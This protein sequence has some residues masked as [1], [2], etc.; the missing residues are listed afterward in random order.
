MFPQTGE[1]QQAMAGCLAVLRRDPQAMDH[2]G[3]DAG[4]LLRSFFAAM[5]VFPLLLLRS[6]AAG[7]PGAT[8]AAAGGGPQLSFLAV[9]LLYVVSWL[10][11]PVAADIVVRALGR[12][13]RQY[14]RY[15]AAYNWSQV[16]VAAL[17]LVATTIAPQF[18]FVA[19]GLSLLYL[20]LLAQSA[21]AITL[22]GAVGLVVLDFGLNLV[23]Q[24]VV[25]GAAGVSETP[26]V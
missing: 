20:A 6:F 8:E 19:L 5:L 2:F 9:L 26:P 12:S 10:I 22:P 18:G 13:D 25:L 21:L 11:W 15:I 24:L 4:A 14:F 3:D 7:A 16:P 23:L 17:L 1:L